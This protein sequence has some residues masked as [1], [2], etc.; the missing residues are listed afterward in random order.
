MARFR[1]PPAHQ[2]ITEA[3]ASRLTGLSSAELL[4]ERD[5]QTLV[6][7]NRDGTSERMLRVPTALILE[8]PDEE[9]P[10]L[11]RDDD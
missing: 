3:D 6:R 8:A 2:L 4:D 10:R 7:V 9:Q 1:K 11:Q 5:V